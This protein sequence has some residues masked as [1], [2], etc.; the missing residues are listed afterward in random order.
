MA[1]LSSVSLLLHKLNVSVVLAGEL[2]PLGAS[3]N[4]VQGHR[5]G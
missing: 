2:R 5:E 1:D 4:H 3:G